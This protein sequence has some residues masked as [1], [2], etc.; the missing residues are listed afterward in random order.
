MSQVIQ[1]K[2]TPTPNNPP[3]SLALGEVAVGI[4]NVPAKM[5]VGTSIGVQQMFNMHVAYAPPAGAAAG[6]LWWNPATSRVLYFDGGSNWWLLNSVETSATPPTPRPDGSLWRHADTNV[7][8]MSYNQAGVTYWFPISGNRSSFPI[9]PPTGPVPVSGDIW[10]S[11]TGVQ[12]YDG[13]A[14]FNPHL[15]IAVDGV[16]I[17]GEGTAGDPFEVAEIDGGDF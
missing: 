14:W 8:S 11:P 5:W 2:R 3:T 10:W 9:S 16:S 7:L 12:V 17:V 13:T 1:L 6:D 15:H 4:A